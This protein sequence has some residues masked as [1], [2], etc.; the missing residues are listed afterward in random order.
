MLV[1]Q[2][3]SVRRQEQAAADSQLVAEI[4]TLLSRGDKTAAC[5]R[6][7]V[8]IDR[9]QRRANRIAFYYL[10]NV[11]EV[12]EAVQDA[13]LKAFLHLSSFREGLYFELWF[14]R[15]VVNGCL[16]RLKAQSR[17]RRWI[18]PVSE[19]DPKLLDQRAN[20]ELSP[21]NVL[22]QRERRTQLLTAVARLPKR[23]R[24]VVVLSQFEEFSTRDVACI[25]K[26][27]ETTVRVHLFRAVRSL[28]KIL[29]T[30]NTL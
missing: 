9:H 25:L 8:I 14:T 3:I 20:R 4:K 17:R 30:E 23:Q 22:L 11:A 27:A 21:E 19:H 1:A 28:R 13:F 16:D 24:A 29:R 15:I 10:R 6:F 5:T 18:V 26:L 7:E 2:A 12:D